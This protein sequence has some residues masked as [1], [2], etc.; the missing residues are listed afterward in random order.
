MA[1]RIFLS[2]HWNTPGLGSTDPI[3]RLKF[4]VDRGL[5]EIIE[6]ASAGAA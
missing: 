2:D 1:H 3:P 4:D 6:S 5:A